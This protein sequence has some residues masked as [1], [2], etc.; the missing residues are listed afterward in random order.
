M[1]VD[2]PFSLKLFQVT[3][4]VTVTIASRCQ[5][6]ERIPTL[7]ILV[8]VR[9]PARHGRG[10]IHQINCGGLLDIVQR[11]LGVRG[12]LRTWPNSAVWQYPL[13]TQNW[14]YLRGI[15]YIAHDVF[16]TLPR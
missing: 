6:V 7:A 11:G 4:H 1:E 3:S 13:M 10:D 16:G 8:A 5:P 12:L 14:E 9:L 15:I 2:E